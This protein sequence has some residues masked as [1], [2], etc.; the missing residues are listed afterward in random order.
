MKN[1]MHKL[2]C[3]LLVI[4]SLLY[5]SAAFS[6]PTGS[7]MTQANKT[8][9]LI[10]GHG[11]PTHA[12]IWLH[13]LGASANDFPPV[14]PELGLIDSRSIRFIFPQA[15][16]RHITVNGGALMPGWYDIRGMDIADKQDAS[17]MAEAKTILDD[18]IEQQIAA[19]ISSENIIIAGFSQGG[20]VAYH[21]GVRSKHTLGGILA[22]STYLP[23]ADLVAQ[24]QSKMNIQTP[25]LANHGTHDP[26]VPLQYGQDSADFLI[27]LGY[28]VK[29]QTYPMAHQ[30]VMEQLKDIGT[31]INKT[32]ADK[33]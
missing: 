25:I 31:W 7:T 28:A 11:E 19:G 30:V 6:Q 18:L 3:Y 23:F 22:L 24:E 17:G 33:K 4:A 26:V 12:I 5:N 29:W 16:D 1:I 9:E 8:I 27:N 2:Q 13:G 15:P 10:H 32:F 14:V 20:A 21:V